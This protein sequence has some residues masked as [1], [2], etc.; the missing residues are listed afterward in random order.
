MPDEQSTMSPAH[1]AA[2]LAKLEAE[3]RAAM[4]HAE[5][6][7]EKHRAEGRKAAAEAE[8][9]ELRL[10]KARHDADREEEKRREELAAHKYHHVYLFKGAVDSQSAAKCM[11]QL[12]AWMRND[13]GCDIEI[14]FNSPGGS[15]VDGMA[16]WDHIQFVRSAGHR[17]T[18]STVGM[19]ASMAGIL[20][21]AGDQRVMGRE[22]WLLIHEASFG[23][24][25]SF[26]DVEDTVEWVRKVQDRILSI[27]A[28][29][30]NMSK[31]AIKRKWHRKDWWISSDEALKLGFVDAVR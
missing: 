31:S 10:T 27:F 17:V 20:L 12:T 25:G 19:A 5:A 29:R 16:L 22:S 3:A 13:P 28:A 6:E 4:L 8:E 9:V 14:V 11:D 1:E 7:A 26:G 2:T 21:Q 30:S 24:S 15:V 23:A 18:T